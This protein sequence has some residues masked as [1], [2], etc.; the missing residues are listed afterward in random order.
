MYS[1]PHSNGP[2]KDCQDRHV[3]CHGKCE[4]YQE[5]DRQNEIN[6]QRK[7]YYAMKLRRRPSWT[8]K[9]KET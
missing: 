7:G 4:K 2:C 3:G 6:R 5:F 9:G 8:E 1:G